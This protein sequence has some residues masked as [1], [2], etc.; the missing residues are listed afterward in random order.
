M[1]AT[2]YPQ[3]AIDHALEWADNQ[4]DGPPGFWNDLRAL[5]FAYRREQSKL[6]RANAALAVA[7]KTIQFMCHDGNKERQRDESLAEINRIMEGK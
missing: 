4:K 1:N 7:R 6:S 5:A 3:S 2:E